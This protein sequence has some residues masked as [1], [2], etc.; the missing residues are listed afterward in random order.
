MAGMAARVQRPIFSGPDA[1]RPPSQAARSCAPLVARQRAAPSLMA[2]GTL[3]AGS[4]AAGAAADGPFLGLSG[5]LICGTT[6]CSGRNLPGSLAFSAALTAVL[7]KGIGV[8]AAGAGADADG[9]SG[10]GSTDCEDWPDAAA[11]K[12]MA[13][14]APKTAT[15]SD[16]IQHPD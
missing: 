2:P 12:T 3:P 16:F 8:E 9:D 15:K 5:K 11:A 14:T 6:R 7:R 10:G 1:G 4:E 13:I